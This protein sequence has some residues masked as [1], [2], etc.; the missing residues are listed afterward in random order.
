MR[1]S[2]D[3]YSKNVKDS[4]KDFT[5]G[6]KAVAAAMAGVAVAGAATYKA[7]SDF[8]ERG[9]DIARNAAILGLTAEAY[10]ELSY[11]AKMADVDQESFAA[12]SKKLN[13]S[14]GQLKMGTGALYT[15]LKKTNPQLALQL[16]N[17]KNTD[18]AFMLIAGAI[19][20]ETNVQKRATLA[21][22]A[23]G[24]SGQELIPM[25]EGLADARKKAHAAGAIMTNEEV[26]NA[27]R[28]DDSLKRIKI[29]G[30]GI[31]NSVLSKA[32][33]K[34]APLVEMAS[35]WVSKNREMIGLKID[36]A[37][38]AIGR[39]ADVVASLWRTGIIQAVLIMIG[40]FKAFQ[41]AMVIVTAA[42]WALNIAMDANPIGLI[43]LA[44]VSLI[45]YLIILKQHWKEWGGIMSLAMG[46]LGPMVLLIGQLAE[47]WKSLN[48]SFTKG[49][50]LEGLKTL[51][52]TILIA[53][54]KPLAEVTRLIGNLTGN[55]MIKDVSAQYSSW[56]ADLSNN[57]ARYSTP[58]SPQ[59]AAIESRSYSESRSQLDVN[60]A[61]APG[62]VVS[63][64]QS[65]K[66]PGI[67]VN[68]GQTLGVAQ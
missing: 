56:M 10:Q 39:A 41:A 63:A 46:P 65:G 21:Q 34:F 14:L 68:M 55:K 48:D 6:S 50:F 2:I 9:D 16:K 66:A 49:G 4:W 1:A 61:A 67:S 24:K 25:M 36:K 26:A 12:A 47:S 17:A 30:M 3:K 54:I 64:K 13:N 59:A 23:F 32:A 19:S 58:V 31:V 29:A 20:K 37:F 11:A 53:L 44:V 45:G 51:G 40:A 57:N 8:A 42:Q 43:I 62:A 7:V 15:D 33:A 38:D 18:D 35:D 52:Q 60:V 27:S 5:K 28:M 22:A